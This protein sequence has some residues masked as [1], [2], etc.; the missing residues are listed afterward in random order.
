MASQVEQPMAGRIIQQ[1][2]AERIPPELVQKIVRDLVF[3]SHEGTCFT[4]SVLLVCKKW[5]HAAYPILLQEVLLDYSGSRA[6]SKELQFVHNVVSSTNLGHMVRCLTLR[7]KPAHSSGLVEFNGVIQ[8]LSQL[9]ILSIACS[10]SD[11]R[12]LAA[13]HNLMAHIQPQ[14]KS[15]ELRISSMTHHPPSNL[16]NYV[17]P[18]YCSQGLLNLRH[19]R[20][21]VPSWLVSLWLDNGLFLNAYPE[22]TEMYIV[23][24]Q[25]M[26]ILNVHH[27]EQQ[28]D[29]S[30][31]FGRSIYGSIKLKRLPRLQSCKMVHSI[32]APGGG[33]G[34]TNL[35]TVFERINRIEVCDATKGM[36]Y[37]FPLLRLDPWID[38]YWSQFLIPK[39]RHI[40]SPSFLGQFQ[41][42]TYEPEP[43]LL[44]TATVGSLRQLLRVVDNWSWIWT[45]RSTRIPSSIQG[46][47]EGGP[48]AS[49]NLERTITSEESRWELT[50][51]SGTMRDFVYQQWA[52]KEVDARLLPQTVQ[53]QE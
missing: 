15:F 29:L 28:E 2:A 30:A 11:A 45:D 34:S 16:S 7:F 20:Y 3:T 17:F 10:L 53:L 33:I 23:L 14:V 25:D 37:R 21:V 31:R 26:R 41:S 12:D 22:L 24:T 42:R 13:A 47:S 18:P 8:C 4:T 38:F 51:I 50:D 19:M 44:L 43:E 6:R 27:V 40:D 52:A 48:F 49:T 32:I 39:K 5:H 9:Q 46:T 36:L 35:H 1:S